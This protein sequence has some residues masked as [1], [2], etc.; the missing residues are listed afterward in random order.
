[1]CKRI[2]EISTFVKKEKRTMSIYFLVP[3]RRKYE[4][5]FEMNEIDIENSSNKMIPRYK[6]ILE[7]W[8][9][10]LRERLSDDE[11]GARFSVEVGE[12]YHA[13]K[14]RD[15]ICK[16]GRIAYLGGMN[17]LAEFWGDYYVEI[18][19]EEVL[20]LPEIQQKHPEFEKLQKPEVFNRVYP[21]HYQVFFGERPD[22]VI[23]PSDLIWSLGK[24]IREPVDTDKY[25][26]VRGW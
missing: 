14:Q 4:K 18:D 13:I 19:F 11:A 21:A 2:V 5:Y 1:M 15:F 17:M 25:E 23:V 7:I 16:V 20:K 6:R 24:W 12:L 8:D 3:A 26:W 22:E 9:T 10:C